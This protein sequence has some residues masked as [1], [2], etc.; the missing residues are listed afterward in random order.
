MHNYLNCGFV[1][2]E[3]VKDLT[4]NNRKLLLIY[5]AYRSHTTLNVLDLFHRNKIIVYALAAHT[6]RKTEPLDV[7]MFSPFKNALNESMNLACTR[8]KTDGLHVFEFC[9]MLSYAYRVSFSEKNI[10]TAFKKSGIWP[11]DSTQLLSVPRPAS[12]E[13]GD[14]ILDVEKL[15]RHF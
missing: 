3:S 7:V 6:S 13:R 4:A 5:D 9:G 11:V 2:V 10:I 14:D 15:E 8:G 12:A 1:F